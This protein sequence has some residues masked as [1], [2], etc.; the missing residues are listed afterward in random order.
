ML[1]RRKLKKRIALFLLV[2]T[3][4]YTFFPSISY[5]LTSGPTAPE[6][7]SFEPVDTT[8]MVNPLTGDFTYNLPLLEVP[9]PGGGYPINLSYHAGIQPNEEASWAGWGWTINPGSIN[10][11]IN[12]FADDHHEIWNTNRFFWEGGKTNTY[13]LGVN[14]GLYGNAGASFGASISNDTY[15]G[16]GVGAYVGGNFGLGNGRFGVGGTIGVGPYGGAYASAGLNASLTPQQSAL[17]L[18][19]SLGVSTNFSNVNLYSGISLRGEG[20]SLVGVSLSTASLKPSLTIGGF[21]SN[22]GNSKSGQISTTSNSTDVSIPILPGLSLDLGHAYQRYWIDEIDETAVNGSLHFPDFPTNTLW[23]D[24]HAYDTY[25][26]LD[27][28]LE[29]GIVDNPDPE[30]VLGGSF[31]GFDN[32]NVQAQGVSGSMRPYAYQTYLSRQNSFRVANFDGKKGNE[33]RDFVRNYPLGQNEYAPQ[34]RF[35]NDFSNRYEYDPGDIELDENLSFDFNNGSEVLTGENGNEAFSENYL[36]GSRHV[37]YLTNLEITNRGSKFTQTGFIE[38]NATGFD[39]SVQDRDQIGGFVVTNE[40]GMKYYFS[41]PAY[42]SS[43]YTYSENIT[44]GE[45]H[46]YNEIFKPEKYAYTW[47]LTAVTGPDFVDRGEIGVLDEQDW[48]YWVGFDYGKWTDQ[49]A[50]RTPGEDFVKDLDENFQVFSKGKKELYYLDRV[51]TKSHSAVFVKEIRHDGKSAIDFFMKHRDQEHLQVLDEMRAGGYI[52]KQVSIPKFVELTNKRPAENDFDSPLPEPYISTIPG[53]EPFQDAGNELVIKVVGN[54]FKGL[55][56]NKIEDEKSVYEDYRIEYT[57]K[58]VSS[59]KLKNILLLNND[60]YESLNLDKSAGDAYQQSYNYSV[61]DVFDAP[62]FDGFGFNTQP[63]PVTVKQHLPE[64]VIDIYDLDQGYEQSAIRVIDLE[65]DYSLAPNTANS[66]DS[67]IVEG[68]IEAPVGSENY[69]LMGRLTLKKIEF[70]GKNGT[71]VTPP[72][73]FGYDLDEKER[74]YGSI[75]RINATEETDYFDLTF[76]NKSAGLFN[77]G[78]LIVNDE[79]IINNLYASV[80][81]VL[82][83]SKNDNNT[84]F[85]A[86]KL[87]ARPTKNPDARVRTTKNPVYSK[88]AH[89][90]WGMYKPDVNKELLE[91]NENIARRVSSISAQSTDVWSLREIK[92]PLGANIKIQYEPD[93]YNKEILNVG[94]NLIVQDVRESAT[95]V[96]KV[97]ITIEDQLQNDIEPGDFVKIKLLVTQPVNDGI[98]DIPSG[99]TYLDRSFDPSY[100]NVEGR[101]TKVNGNNLEVTNQSFYDLLSSKRVRIETITGTSDDAFAERSYLGRLDFVAGNLEVQK[102]DISIFGGNIRVKNIGIEDFSDRLNRTNYSYDSEGGQS[103]GVTSFAPGGV[104]VVEF[105]FPDNDHYDGSESI[106]PEDAEGEYKKLVFDSFGKLLANSREVPAPGVMYEHVKIQQ[107]VIVDSGEEQLFPNYSKYHYKVFNEGMIGIQQLSDYQGDD[108]GNYEGLNYTKKKTKKTVLK[109]YTAQIGNLKSIKLFDN[110]DQLIS[111]TI[112]TYLGD[113][114]TSDMIPENDNDPELPDDLEAN[115]KYYEQDV[116]DLLG[117]QGIIQETFAEARIVRI[118]DEDEGTFNQMLGIVSKKEVYP[119]I[120]TGQINKN[121]KTGIVTR[122]NNLE[123]DYYSGQITKSS[124]AD[125]YGNTYVSVAVPAYKVSTE[126]ITAYPGMGLAMDGGKNMLTQ[127]GHNYTYKH[128]PDGNHG[129]VT[130]SIQTWSDNTK[131]LGEDDLASQGIWRKR[132]N[133]TWTGQ[134]ISFDQLPINGLYPLAQISEFDAWDNGVPSSNSWEKTNEITLVDVYSHPIESKNINGNYSSTKLDPDLERVIAEVSNASYD[135]AIYSGVEYISGSEAFEA[136]ILIGEGFPS[137]VRSHTGEYSLQVPYGT[138]GFAYTLEM[139]KADLDKKYFASIWVYL[140]GQSET[141]QQ[142][143]GAQLFYTLD[144]GTEHVVYPE[145][146]KNKSKTWYLLEL[147]ID[148]EDSESV[149]VG[150]RNNTSRGVYFDDFRVHPIDASMTSYVYDQFTGEL[151]YILDRDNFYTHFEYDAIGRLV[152]TSRELLNFDFGE[153]KESFRADQILNET[154]Y[155][156]GESQ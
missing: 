9:G 128:D 14:V 7:T 85:N 65:T 152:R 95:E 51:F 68:D 80:Y 106:E 29:G 77:E 48:G 21:R 24:R 69:P 134:D 112:N 103:S 100:L 94:Q 19:A 107:S 46:S 25:S 32:Y 122:T 56:G 41:L 13:K 137:T 55:F 126:E 116:R 72:I 73:Q 71:A 64:N 16:F 23:S 40:S 127:K 43:E 15:K 133:Y 5:A 102:S 75:R 28:D 42:S 12:G 104:E 140:P 139:N 59:L 143:S 141:E 57:P 83:E 145:L 3:L 124:S 118:E 36:A 149:R 52:P 151:I 96:G 20:A 70:K 53:D 67:K 113:D 138:E 125:S 114:I 86:R 6:A 123:F 156:Y 30:K 2:H 97:N 88:D 132:A 111:S 91:E 1:K 131:V 89:D 22:V 129:L 11:N 58:P 101:V 79:E 142:I 155:N 78:D 26:L 31:A 49:Y 120:Q 82:L 10:R 136:D 93:T 135:E 121:Y 39:R 27:T 150:C 153:G 45:G 81:Y 17:G 37:E 148:P 47:Y 60:D 147:E 110:N 98:Y 34:F 146:Q 4:F 154:I 119:S 74:V 115:I 35:I 90:L 44:K 87:G 109:D 99:Q 105:S 63:A 84:V 108:S 18:G 66:F 117:G 33:R 130:A 54:F 76:D 8:D 62:M 50:W 38:T 92:T 61:V 144:D